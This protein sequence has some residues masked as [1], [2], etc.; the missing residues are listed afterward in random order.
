[1]YDT[2]VR[3][4]NLVHDATGLAEEGPLGM[5]GH[6]GQMQWREAFAGVIDISRRRGPMQA[7]LPAPEHRQ[8]GADAQLEG[9]RAG[10]P[11]AGRNVRLEFECATSQLDTLLHELRRHA[12][13]ERDGRVA[14]ACARG[15]AIG[16]GEVDDAFLVAPGSH[17]YATAATG[18]RVAADATVHGRRDDAA[19]LMVLVIAREFGSTGNADVVVIDGSRRLVMLR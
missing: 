10:K 16:I 14:L 5:Q 17:V 6:L 12:A 11:R 2:A 4:G 8:R 13:Y 1:M 7:D 19:A 3:A 9:R 15:P 18:V